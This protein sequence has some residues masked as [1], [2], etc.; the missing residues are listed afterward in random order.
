MQAACMQLH[1]SWDSQEEA[2]RASDVEGIK[3]HCSNFAR[4]LDDFQTVMES[5]SFNPFGLLRQRFKRLVDENDSEENKLLS[6][7]LAYERTEDH[8][9]G[10]AYRS[11]LSDFLALEILGQLQE[12]LGKGSSVG[13]YIA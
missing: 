11:T 4:I 10:R 8:L 7:A 9:L 13:K 5:T 6:E 3:N 2:S 1:K 12:I